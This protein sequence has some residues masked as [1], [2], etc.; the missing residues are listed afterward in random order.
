MG[1]V[2]TKTVEISKYRYFRK[3]SKT[4]ERALSERRRRL[5]DVTIIIHG[6]IRRHHH[7]GSHCGGETNARS[8]SCSHANLF[9]LGSI[10][11]ISMVT[12]P[13]R[14]IGSTLSS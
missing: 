1:E 9:H 3:R 12:T 4:E 7:V 6:I 10:C 2:A 5:K 8:G 11:V 13:K 14:T